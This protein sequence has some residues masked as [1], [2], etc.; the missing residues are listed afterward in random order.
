M[1]TVEFE[2]DASI[3]TTIDET[4]AYF[5]VQMI[6]SDNGS[7]LVRQYLDDDEDPQDVYMSY[8]QLMDLMASI[9]QTEGAYYARDV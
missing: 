2:P 3:I 9:H 7:V 8:Q 5:E 4:D 6:I 1:F